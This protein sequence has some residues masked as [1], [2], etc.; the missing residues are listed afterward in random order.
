VAGRNITYLDLADIKE[1]I[2]VSQSLSKI[3][4]VKAV[5]AL[6]GFGLKEAKDLVESVWSNAPIRPPFG[7]DHIPPGYVSAVWHN[8]NLHEQK[9]DILKMVRLA[10]V[11]EKSEY[12]GSAENRFADAFNISFAEAR[13]V[14]DGEVAENDLPF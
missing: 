9:K 3:G 8:T 1:L 14:L 6:T 5:R 12:F 10:L 13:K 11:D 7:S 4:A 2:K